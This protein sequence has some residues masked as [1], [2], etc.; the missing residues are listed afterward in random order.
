[1]IKRVVRTVAGIGFT[2]ERGGPGDP[3]EWGWADHE[4]IRNRTEGFFAQDDSRFACFVED[5]EQQKWKYL[6]VALWPGEPPELGGDEPPY[7][8][9]I[10]DRQDLAL[11]WWRHLSDRRA[12]LASASKSAIVEAVAAWAQVLA[13]DEG[14]ASFWEFADKTQTS[15][16]RLLAEL[17]Q[18]EWRPTLLAVAA[19]LQWG[20]TDHLMVVSGHL[21]E[22]SLLFLHYLNQDPSETVMCLDLNPNTPILLARAAPCGEERTL[23]EIRTEAPWSPLSALLIEWLGHVFVDR[24]ENIDLETVLPSGPSAKRAPIPPLS[25]QDLKLVALYQQGM[26]AKEIAE[27]LGYRANTVTKR[28]SEIRRVAPQL[29]PYRNAAAATRAREW[30][31]AA[32]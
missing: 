31:R 24:I 2:L 15:S 21:Y 11:H 29:L 1:M 20:I 16:S 10:P 3:S 27:A 32:S 8:P 23:L 7:T 17:R 25:E 28:I 4:V 22:V 13:D 12:V 14:V 18:F 19:P 9:T 26:T 6:E 5:W 30:W